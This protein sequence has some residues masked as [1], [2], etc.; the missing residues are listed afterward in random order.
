MPLKSDSCKI[1]T[2]VKTAKDIL[3]VLLASSA[4]TEEACEQFIP[5]QES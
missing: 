1:I 4:A 2:H 3:A 5:G